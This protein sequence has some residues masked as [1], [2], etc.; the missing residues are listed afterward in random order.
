[1]GISFGKHRSHHHLHH[2]PDRNHHPSFPSTSTTAPNHQLLS[3]TTTSAVVANTNSDHIT[4]NN[5]VPFSSNS[6]TNTVLPSPVPPPSY[7]F[8][9]H[10]PYLPSPS[11]PPTTFPSSSFNSQNYFMPRPDSFSTLTSGRVLHRYASSGPPVALPPRSQAPPP[12]YVDHNHA[13]KIK[14][15]VNVHKDNITLVVDEKNL[16]SHLV[17][18]TFDAIVDGSITISY[19]AKEE[20]NC[21]FVPLYPEIYMP[22]R[23]PFKKGLGQKFCQPSGTGIDLGFFELD[24]LSKPTLEEDMFPLV[25]CAEASL[26]SLFAAAE[27]DQPLPTMSPHAQIS[28]AVLDKNNEGHFQVKIVKQVLW[29]EGVRYELREIYGFGNSFVSDFDDRETG[30]ECVICMTEPKDTA[31]LPCRHMVRILILAILLL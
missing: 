30:K 24:Q 4:Q 9:A 19:F 26:P 7:A 28:Q 3:P 15:D 23:I 29:I 14:N 21:R 11:P 16:D 17:S 31:V 22:R 20:V 18:F 2:H 12:P 1:M 27:A 25:I 13:K 6:L 8:A 10:A 5:P